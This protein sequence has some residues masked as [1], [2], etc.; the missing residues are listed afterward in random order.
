MNAFLHIFSTY[1]FPLYMAPIVLIFVIIKLHLRIKAMK[2]SVLKEIF[3]LQWM[4]I[5]NVVVMFIEFC[6][7]CGVI[8]ERRKQKQ[9]VPLAYHLFKVEEYQEGAQLN[10]R[11]KTSL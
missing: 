3:V 11:R 5:I 4:P 6:T 10:V 1:I 2:A 7:L 8:H 9:T